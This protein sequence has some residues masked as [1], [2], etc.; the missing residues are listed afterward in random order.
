MDVYLIQEHDDE[1]EVLTWFT[2]QS[3]SS[4]TVGIFNEGLDRNILQS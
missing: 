4:G 1:V 3:W 2:L